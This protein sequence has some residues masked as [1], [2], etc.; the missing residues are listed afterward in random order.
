MSG[1]SWKKKN[2]IRISTVKNKKGVSYLLLFILLG[3]LAYS[4]Q[5]R[6][7][8]VLNRKRMER[9]MYDVYIAEATIENDY[10]NFDT[11]EKKEAYINRVFKA[12]RVTPAQW[13]SSLSWYSD[14]IDLYLK[15]N[16]SVKARLQRARQEVDALVAQQ[17]RANQIDPVL[18]PPS[19]LPPLYMFS[20]PDT[21]KGFRFRLDSAEIS[22]KVTGDDFLFSFS[23][24]GIPSRF[25]SPFTS[26]LTLVYSDTTIYR[27]QQIKENKTY[28]FS[29]S[30]YIPDDTITGITGFVHL[31][32]STGVM[33]HIQLY[34]IYFGDVQPCFSETD[35]LREDPGGEPLVP[36]SVKLLDTDSAKY[37]LPDS[38]PDSVRRLKPDSGGLLKPDSVKPLKPASGSLLSPDS[39]KVVERRI[40]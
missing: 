7:G 5:N 38:T 32:D 14:R 15:M 17:N 10:R 37:S 2:K 29:G 20:M 33:P 23:T 16:D 4:C 21:K 3:G 39:V 18:L 11:P 12:H 13:D 31:Q 28:E 8:E 9:L 34:N 19:Y 36:D 35:S 30:K 1:K 26:L 25:S 24:I 6:P 27:F 22:S 40:L